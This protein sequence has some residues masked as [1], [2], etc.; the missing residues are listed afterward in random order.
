MQMNIPEFCLVVLFGGHNQAASFIER[1]FESAERILFP[2]AA[3]RAATSVSFAEATLAIANRLN[4]RDLAVT[5]ATDITSRDRAKL[6]S[7][8]K[9]YYALQVAI[10]LDPKDT[11]TCEGGRSRSA[12]PP[13]NPAKLVGE[14][15]RSVH[16]ISSR[17]ELEATRVVREPL[18][19][20][21]R[22]EKGPFDIIGD[23]HG[24]AAELEAL[25]AKLGYQIK[26]IGREGERDYRV[27]ENSGRRAIFV[28]DLVDRGSR[29]PDVL[30]L[31]MAMT[32]AGEAL[33]V[34]GNHDDKLLRWLKGRD[35]KVTHGL[36]KSTEQM[37][38]TPED[39]KD[40]VKAFLEGLPSHLWLDSGRLVVAH[41]GIAERMIGRSRLQFV[42]FVFTARQQGRKTNMVFRSVQIGR[43][44][45]GVR[46]NRL[47]AYPYAGADGSTTRSASTRVACSGA[48]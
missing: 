41:A 48:L 9:Q 2:G 24:C 12:N 30:S 45:R 28:G 23:I 10:I 6:I 34:I 31:V 1:N 19:V 32:Q 26:R 17:E 42:N 5:D 11:K 14:G 44:D 18:P 38:P 33:C 13:P 46:P 16:H 7:I 8:A 43:P 40:R 37:A 4:N 22:N 3:N 25:L 39:F 29:T 21:M 27:L 20:D 15:F 47:R 36:E 35:V